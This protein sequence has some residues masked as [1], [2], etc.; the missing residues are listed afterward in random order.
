[1]LTTMKKQII[2]EL[3]K[4]EDGYMLTASTPHHQRYDLYA[5]GPYETLDKVLEYA[6][7]DFTVEFFRDYFQ[8]TGFS[9]DFHTT[10]TDGK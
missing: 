2:I 10:I 7:P 4:D 8:D 3:T 9:M 5:M 1:M 6:V